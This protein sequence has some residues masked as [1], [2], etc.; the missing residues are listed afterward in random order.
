MYVMMTWM[1]ISVLTDISIL[2]F[3]RYIRYS[4][5]YKLFKI[6]KYI[7]FIFQNYFE[8]IKNDNIN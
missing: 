7:Q 5:I 4:G 8:S 1:K 3:Y 2:E 6:L